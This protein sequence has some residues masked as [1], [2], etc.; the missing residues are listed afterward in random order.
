MEYVKNGYETLVFVPVPEKI[1]RIRRCY[2]GKDA[3]KLD[4]WIP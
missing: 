3:I 4:F 2:R 1:R